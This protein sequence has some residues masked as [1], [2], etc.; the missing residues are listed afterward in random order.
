ME[1]IQSFQV[2][3]EMSPT[4]QQQKRT[5]KHHST[6]KL[7][8]NPEQC[9]AILPDKVSLS[10]THMTASMFTMDSWERGPKECV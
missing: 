1:G 6:P 5:G 2:E 3:G 9:Q 4:K 8:S 7:S 10:H